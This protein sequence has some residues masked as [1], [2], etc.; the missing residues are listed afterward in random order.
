MNRTW[1]LMHGWKPPV[2]ARWESSDGAWVAIVDE[3]GGA[4]RVTRSSGDEVRC[5]SFPEAL[6]VAYRFQDVGG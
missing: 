3:T 2:R 1:K 4:F 5:Q 6:E